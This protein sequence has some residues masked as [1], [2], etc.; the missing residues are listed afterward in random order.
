[1]K[2]LQWQT[3]PFPNLLYLEWLFLGLSL[4]TAFFH[5]PVNPK[6]LALI[7][8]PLLQNL[9]GEIQ[10]AVVVVVLLI[11][12]SG[13]WLP[14]E[15]WRWIYI[16]IQLGLCWLAVF[17]CQ[18]EAWNALVITRFMAFLLLVVVIRGCLI[19]STRGRQLVL[20]AAYI[21]L[22]IFIIFFLFSHTPT[23]SIK[24]LAGLMIYPI[25]TFGVWIILFLML[26]QTLI[27]E[28]QGRE[29]LAE[30]HRQLQ[31]YAQLIEGQ[32]ILRERTYIAREIHDA[33]GHYLATQSI[34]LENARLLLEQDVKKTAYFLEK[35]K[36]LGD[37][38]IRDMHHSLSLLSAHPL[39]NEP[40]IIAF[41]RLLQN[42][43]EST[44]IKLDNHVQLEIDLSTEIAIALYRI[45]QEALTNVIKHSQATE[46]NINLYQT[47]DYITLEIQDNGIGFN[48]EDNLAG[49][50]LQSMR[51]RTEALGGVFEVISQPHQGCNVNVK[52]R[53]YLYEYSTSFS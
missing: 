32:A 19:F 2:S 7:P 3:H 41:S 13:L 43:Q 42:F 49:F 34:Q 38:A 15:G 26:I 9:S 22:Q 23:L 39:G 11:G 46:V 1:M 52:I 8:S 36:E 27:S 28:R 17:L 45:A 24:E 18:Q 12:V 33:V 25:L 51:D 44:S 40:F 4:V 10:I 50:G 6:Y 37:I 5:L 31:C 35:A 30:S 48:I 20:L 21:S 14:Q 29:E 47:D 53:E 16:T